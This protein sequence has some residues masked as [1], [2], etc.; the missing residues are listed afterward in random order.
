MRSA[1]SIS[2]QFL[3]FEVRSLR[4]IHTLLDSLLR[5]EESARLSLLFLLEVLPLIV[6]GPAG[7]S[8][9][10]KI[11]PENFERLRNLLVLHFSL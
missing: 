11:G 10:L 2:I 4:L 9:L 3:P 1:L 8:L 7:L 6:L 5:R